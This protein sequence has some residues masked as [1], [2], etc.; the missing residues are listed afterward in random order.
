MIEVNLLPLELRKAERTP[1]PR[2]M[3]I[4]GGTALICVL[5]VFLMS[6]LQVINKTKKKLRDEK[7]KQPQL[8]KEAD[9]VKELKK[10]REEFYLRQ[11]TIIREFNNRITWGEK[12]WHLN[13]IVNDAD[14]K[15][16]WI[17][18]L[19]IESKTRRSG[20]RQSREN[21]LKIVGFAF[22]DDLTETIAKINSFSRT[23]RKNEDF[24]KDFKSDI[25]DPIHKVIEKKTVRVK[26]DELKLR[27]PKKVQKFTF[28][29][30][31]KERE[32]PK[33]QM[34]PGIQRRP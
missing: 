6:R 20:R 16:L 4:M 21:L 12:L 17:S 22:D 28:T 23:L 10:K 26:S 24:F 3:T 8:Q 19:Y 31:F 30:V 33:S 18:E 29:L 5:G 2:L 25:P 11:K 15:N 27:I 14:F 9:E 13:M 7:A 32:K 1:L 34:P